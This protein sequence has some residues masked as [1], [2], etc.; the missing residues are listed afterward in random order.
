MTT[1]R[2]RSP[3][4]L[5]ARLGALSLS[6]L[7]LAT[8]G[9]SS[10]STG[11]ATNSMSYGGTVA[12]PHGT[13]SFTFMFD[14]PVAAPPAPASGAALSAPAPVHGL[15]HIMR[16]ADEMA[17][18]QGTWDGGQLSFTG[19]G[20][21]LTGVMSGEVGQGTFTGPYGSGA[22]VLLGEGT[23][24]SS[25]SFC[26]TFTGS[27]AGGSTA[28]SFSLTIAGSRAYGIIFPTSGASAGSAT[29]FTGSAA[30]M[31]MNLSAPGANPMTATGMMAADRMSI[32]GSYTV[33]DA[34][35]AMIESGT[36]SGPMCL[37]M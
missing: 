9:C 19:G 10:A 20:Y 6:M 16:T 23:P 14:A 31:T 11:A 8:I 28:G 25:H 27:D 13:A 30:G 12:D 37:G 5:D 24:G 2:S 21:T 17:D 22:F 1:S 26:G 36:W 18:V 34:G 4:R 3:L 32:S 33:K 35:G 29:V 15:G 7:A